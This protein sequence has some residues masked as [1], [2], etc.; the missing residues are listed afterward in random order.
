MADLTM[1]PDYIV[2]L[3]DENGAALPG[4]AYDV[5]SSDDAVARPGDTGGAHWG[6]VSVAPGTATIHVVRHSDGATGT[7]KTVEVTAA[8][9]PGFEWSFGTPVPGIGF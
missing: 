1:L 8:A 5:T 4:A 9:A 6:I 7:D 2:P 3:L